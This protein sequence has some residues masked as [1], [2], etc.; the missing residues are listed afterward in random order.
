MFQ[1]MFPAPINLNLV[2]FCTTKRLA[3]FCHYKF[4]NYFYPD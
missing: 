1:K 3:I 2:K 4:F